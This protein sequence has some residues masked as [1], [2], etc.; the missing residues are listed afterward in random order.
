MSTCVPRILSA[1]FIKSIPFKIQVNDITHEIVQQRKQE[2]T[3]ARFSLRGHDSGNINSHSF[4]PRLKFPL[5]KTIV[6][7]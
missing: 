7:T 1:L 2:T 4:Q 3:T 6:V 5:Q